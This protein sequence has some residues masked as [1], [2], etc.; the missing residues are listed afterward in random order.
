MK[1]ITRILTLKNGYH[2]WSHTFNLGAKDKLLCVHGGPGDTHEVFERFGQELETLDIEVTMYDQLGSW[3][4]DTPDWDN[5]E[6]FKKYMSED[7]YL[8]E[9]EEVRQILGYDD[10]YLAGHSWGGML[11]M[12]YANKFQIHL[13][14]LIIIGMIDNIPDYVDNMKKIRLQEFSSAENAYMEDIEARGEWKDA[15]YQKY[16]THLYHEYI[17]RRQPEKKSHLIDIQDKQVYNNFQGDNEF[18]VVGDLGDWDFSKE[19]RTFKI[20]TLL[21]FGDHETIP[22][23]TAKKMNKEIPDSRL[24]VTPDSGH[25]QMIDNP[26]VFFS[27]LR[28]YFLDM[29]AGKSMN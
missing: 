15:Q 1:S 11:S 18:V 26:G 17:N 25:N 4:S 7:Y 24:V 13:K 12:M 8:S 21:S 16:I 3:Y 19:V 5:T 10:F 9:L 14:G 22:L 2:L 20:P 6:I 27:N 23:D 28:N 29:R